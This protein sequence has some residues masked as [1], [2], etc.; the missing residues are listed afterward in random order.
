MNADDS[1]TN[2]PADKNQV[3]LDANVK[4]AKEINEENLK[5]LDD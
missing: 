5:K 3:V 4:T 2:I 1:I